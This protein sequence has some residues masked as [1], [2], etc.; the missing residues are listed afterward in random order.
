ME[1]GIMHY[2]KN[3]TFHSTSLI[4][5]VTAVIEYTIRQNLNNNLLIK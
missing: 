4:K 5:V 2:Y 3:Q 1:L